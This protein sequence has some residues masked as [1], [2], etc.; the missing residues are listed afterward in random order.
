MENYNLFS[1]LSKNFKIGTS[2]SSG[3]NY[4][5]RI[6]VHHRSGGVKRNY[7]LVDF[8][9]RL[10]SFGFVQKIIKD[11]NRTGFLGGILYDN[12]LYAYIVISENIKPGDRIYSGS[13]KN[14]RGIIR[15]GYALPLYLINLFTLVNNIESKPYISAKISRAA[16][17]S[18]LIVGKTLDKII[19]KTKS[20][21]NLHLSKYCLA[22]LGQVSNMLHK[23]FDHKKAG[24][25]VNL[26]KRPIV[27]GLAKN[28]CDHPHG[29]G[30]G[31]KSPLVSP[32]SP[33]G[34]LT[35]GTPSKRKKNINK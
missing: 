11:L 30:E 17:T 19:I 18:S 32:K 9:R 4:L 16:G 15:N 7:I 22:S 23:F 20:G 35:K 13:K 6:C 34:W 3:R 21:W 28:A 31:R 8:F 24:R 26:G 29:G 25:L 27:R 14:F 2:F 33:W 5:G 10:N 12:G 1:F